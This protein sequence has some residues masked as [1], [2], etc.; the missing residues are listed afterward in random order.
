MAVPLLILLGSCPGSVWVFILKDGKI[1]GYVDHDSMR[2]LNKESN[3]LIN[4]TGLSLLR[5]Y[6]LSSPSHRAISRAS[7]LSSWLLRDM[8]ELLIK[9]VRQSWELPWLGLPPLL[10][11]RITRPIISSMIRRKEIVG[12][13]IISCGRGLA[14]TGGAGE[15]PLFP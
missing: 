1:A 7:P 13:R 8:G 3:Q 11:I 6:R 4:A 15:C 10:I 9:A 2:N 14:A 12:P 5:V